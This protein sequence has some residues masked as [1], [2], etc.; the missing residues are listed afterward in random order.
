M[1]NL[2]KYHDSLRCEICNRK[3][4]AAT[5]KNGI[6]FVVCYSHSTDGHWEH[7]L[8]TR[9]INNQQKEV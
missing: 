2:P 8:K 9:K 4:E 7:L 3:C 1:S 6:E 5:I